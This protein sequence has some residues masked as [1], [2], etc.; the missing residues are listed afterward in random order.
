MTGVEVTLVVC[1]HCATAVPPGAYCGNCGAHLADAELNHRRHSYAAAPHESVHRAA[2]VSTLFPH[3]PHRHAHVFREVLV[4][5]LGVVVLLA[6]LRLYT[7]ATLAAAILL[8]VLY[9]LYLYDVEVYEHEPVLVLA[10]TLG[11]GIALGVAYSLFLNGNSTATLS[12]TDR[13]PILSGVILPIVMQVLMVAG[14]LL[15]L[16]RLHFV[17][18]LDGLTF[19]VAAALGFTM[20]MVV[21]GE[22]H[23]LTAA[24]RGTGV[25][26]DSVLRM[27]RAGV[28]AAVVN[29]TTTGL[30]T[31]TLWVLRH[32]R[33]RGRHRSIWRGLPA[34]AVVALLAQIG[35]GLGS[36]FIRDLVLL[37]VVWTVAAALLLVWL[38]VVLHHAL[39]D[40]GGEHHVGAMA[41]CSECHHVVPTMLF[42]PSCGTARSAEPKHLRSGRVLHRGEATS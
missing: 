12:G 39:L 7:P 42:C 26:A 10:A 20:A 11:A 36:Y 27:V 41:V 15:L 17:E 32:G 33:P 6:A 35:L 21:A 30:I 5:G 9:V 24:L 23:V 13:G 4:G 3:L 19:G 34:S 37:V 40:E 18:V 29:A 38:R 22:W 8:P 16:S 2:V 28:I 14:P 31:A 1:R 25:P